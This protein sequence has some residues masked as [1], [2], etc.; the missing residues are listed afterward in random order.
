MQSKTASATNGS[1]QRDLEWVFSTSAQ[2]LLH[3]QT[4]PNPITFEYYL[5]QTS[6]S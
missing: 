5:A 4:E 2:P 1:A 3:L 6:V